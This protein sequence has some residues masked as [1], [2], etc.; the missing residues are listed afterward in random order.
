[1]EP[2][3][4]GRP[5]FT[6]NTITECVTGA[7]VYN[8]SPVFDGNGITHCRDYGMQYEGLCGGG[9]RANTIA[10]NGQDGV[11]ICASAALAVPD[12]NAGFELPYANDFYGNGRYAINFE[13]TTEGGSLLAVFNY[14]GS[15][16]PDSTILFRGPIR[17]SP[18]MDSTHTEILNEDDCPGATEPSTWGAIKAGFR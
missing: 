9:C 4:P 16:C 18:W 2:G 17:F 12:F 3:E 13:C 5:Y 1:S 10:Y 8:S 11:R 6:G 15:R 14:W 7:E